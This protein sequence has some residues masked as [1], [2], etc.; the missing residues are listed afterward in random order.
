ME[1]AYII[2]LILA[3]IYVPFYFWVRYSPKAEKY[4]LR[5]YGPAIMLRTKL[6]TKIIDR[7][8]KYRRFWRF[9]GALSIVLSFIL[10]VTIVY[11]LIVGILNLPSTLNS[12]GLGIQYALAIPGINPLLPIGFGIIG[13]IVAVCL[14]ELAHGMQTASNDMR[15][16]STGVLHLVVPMGAFVEPNEEDVKK[17]SRKVK[18]HLYAAGIATNFIVGI[19]AFMLFAVVMLGGISSPYG[20]QAAVYGVTSNSEAYENGIPAGAI[21]ESVEYEGVIQEF[22]LYDYDITYS[23]NPGDE[24]IVH[25]I[26]ENS[27]GTATITWG[28]YIEKVVSGSPADSIGLQSTDYLLSIT[29]SDGLSTPLYSAN[30]FSDYMR[31]TSPGE[32]VMIEY[33]TSEGEIETVSVVLSSNGSVGYLGISTTTSGM[34]F[35]TPD[36]ILDISRN[37]FYGDETL[38]DYATSSLSYISGPF[39]GFSPMPSSCQWW[40]DVPGDAAVFWWICTLLYWIFWLDIILGVSNAIP[41]VPFDGGFIFIGGIDWLIEKLGIKDRQR[42]EALADKIGSYVSMIVWMAFILVIISIV[43]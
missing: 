7:Y 11:I 25:Y 42:R 24:V 8:S 19:I 6:G 37:P 9:F 41:A 5:K 35:K 23:W 28:V 39:D 2:L 30:Q 13:L 26:T 22:I 21:V 27:T 1:L 12:D 16:D 40:Y 43:I 33:M 34:S 36:E 31:S 15:V 20:D 32:T 29:N 4:G 3:I 38:T 18:L 10:M 17:A 14:H